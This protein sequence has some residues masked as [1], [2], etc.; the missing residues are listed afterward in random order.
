MSLP[1]K[2][3][4]RQ[5]TRAA[6]KA[7]VMVPAQSSP[8]SVSPPVIAMAAPKLAPEVIPSVEGLASALAVI[9]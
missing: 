5:I 2:R 9:V 6:I 3:M 8:K 7:A 1:S 4:R